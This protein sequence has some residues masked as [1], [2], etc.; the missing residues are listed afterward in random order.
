MYTLEEFDKEKTKVFKYITYKK[1]TEHEIRTKFRG[2]IDNNMIDDIIEYLKE[3]G[4]VDDYNFMEKQVNQYMLLKN[5]SIKE[6]KYKLYSKGIEPK[7]IDKYIENNIEELVEYEKKSAKNI[8][9]KK[10]SSMDKEEIKM[11]LLKKGY[12][13]ENI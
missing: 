12:K 8:I 9:N 3:A 11:F 7:L 13:G 1:R 10:S 6:L 2:V 5:M 4:Y